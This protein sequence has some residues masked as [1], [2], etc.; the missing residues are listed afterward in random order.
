[1]KKI[2]ALSALA[3]VA[4]AAVLPAQAATYAIDPSHTF[5]TFEFP[6][7][8]TSTNRG[9]FDKKEGTVEFDRAART[10]RVEL[11]LETASVSSG[12]GAFD[13][14]LRSDDF[15]AAE[16]FPTAK[17]VAD[18]FTF[19]GDK[20]TEVAGQLTLRGKTNPIVLKARNFN[21]YVNPMLKREVCGGDF[22]TT[23]QRSLWGVNFGLN[24][25]MPDNVKLVV[26]VEAIKQ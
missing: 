18:K 2:I 12:T 15:F 25:G 17:F 4:A 8:G 21:C 1:M 24:M 16:Q 7:F 19:D 9:R 26:Q 3:T 5:V 22:E 23:M 14:H 20:V 13:K 6:H 10:G 11:T